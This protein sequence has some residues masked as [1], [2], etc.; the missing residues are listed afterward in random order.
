LEKDFERV[1]EEVVGAGKHEEYHRL[2]EK[3]EKTYC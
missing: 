3:L 1:E 2:L